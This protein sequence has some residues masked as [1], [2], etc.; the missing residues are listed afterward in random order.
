MH[1]TFGGFEHLQWHDSDRVLIIDSQEK[2]YMYDRSRHR[3]DAY[4]AWT[5]NVGKND[6][7]LHLGLQL[8]HG[9]LIFRLP[10]RTTPIDTVCII[11]PSHCKTLLE[12]I[13]EFLKCKL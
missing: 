12:A 4:R 6:G 7:A 5:S 8:P 10:A 11:A 1:I 3:P 2:P 13:G 9:L